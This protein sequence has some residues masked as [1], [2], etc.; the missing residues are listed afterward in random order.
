MTPWSFGEYLCSLAERPVLIEWFGEDRVVRTAVD[1]DLPLDERIEKTVTQAGYDYELTEEWLALTPQRV[2]PD[3]R[4]FDNLLIWSRQF[5]PPVGEWAVV[6]SD[7]IAFQLARGE[8]VTLSDFS[9]RMKIKLGLVA[10]CFTGS[11]FLLF[12]AFPKLDDAIGGLEWL[13]GARIARSDLGYSVT[14]DGKRILEKRK[15]QAEWI[16]QHSPRADRMTNSAELELQVLDRV[17][18]ENLEKL[19]MN[20]ELEVLL[21]AEPG[22]PTVSLLIERH[23]L[24]CEQLT[25]QGQP[26]PELADPPK[27]Q[28]LFSGKGPVGAQAE[29]K[30][31]LR[32][33]F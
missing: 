17:G 9:Q 22:T 1:P 28:V 15:I 29:G 18:P 4:D 10:P 26:P 8:S 32:V 31:G 2:R 13:L 27:F 11:R 20:W 7:A 33:V 16:A 12:G 3:L 5:K 21:D 30:N 23:R 6:A 24:L 25:R 19:F 14:P